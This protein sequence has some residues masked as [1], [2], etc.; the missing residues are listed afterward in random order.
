MLLSVDYVASREQSCH[1][2]KDYIHVVVKM[3]MYTV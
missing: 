3:L 1:L 2:A